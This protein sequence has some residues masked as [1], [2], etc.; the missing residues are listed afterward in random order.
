MMEM[1]LASTAVSHQQSHHPDPDPGEVVTV[2]PLPVA[3]STDENL[4]RSAGT[5]AGSCARLLFKLPPVKFWLA[6]LVC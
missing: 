5:A 3:R 4:H 2:A 6:A 1:R